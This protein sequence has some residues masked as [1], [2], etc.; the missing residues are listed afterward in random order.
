MLAATAAAD[1]RSLAFYGSSDEPSIFGTAAF[2]KYHIHQ[3]PEWTGRIQL[4]AAG[5][6]GAPST[7]RNSSSTIKRDLRPASGGR[8]AAVAGGAYAGVPEGI[9][10]PVLDQLVC[11]LASSLMLNVFS[12]FSQLVRPVLVPP[13]SPLASFPSPLSP[14][15][16]GIPRGKVYAKAGHPPTAPFPLAPRPQVMGHIGVRH[17]DRLGFVRSLTPTH[18]RNLGINVDFWRRQNPFDPGKL[19]GIRVAWD[20]AHLQMVQTTGV[21]PETEAASLPVKF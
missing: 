21:V 17:A 19:L 16:K 6:R 1:G 3:L 5:L 7:N 13:F 8:N 15:V 4:L 11:S 10:Q 9:L 18:Q 20:P 14:I 12:T 2:R